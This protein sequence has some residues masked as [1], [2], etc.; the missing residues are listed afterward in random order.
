MYSPSPDSGCST[1]PDGA[2]I[3]SPENVY[4]QVRA[5]TF[6]LFEQAGIAPFTAAGMLAKLQLEVLDDMC[7]PDADDADAV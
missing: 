1:P 2:Q 6:L 5:V 3:I 4:A 7:E